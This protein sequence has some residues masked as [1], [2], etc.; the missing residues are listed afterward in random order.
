MHDRCFFPSGYLDWPLCVISIELFLLIY[1]K[2]N[3]KSVFFL[4][5]ILQTVHSV[6]IKQGQIP[7]VI[8]VLLQLL[9]CYL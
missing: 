9:R 5:L 3:Q 7:Y 1:N 8:I 4:F 2:R 6:W